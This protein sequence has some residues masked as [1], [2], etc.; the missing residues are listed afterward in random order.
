MGLIYYDSYTWD[1]YTWDWY[2]APLDIKAPPQ[3]I[4][5]ARQVGGSTPLHAAVAANHL[6]LVIFLVEQA[7]VI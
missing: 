5:G 4:K 2:N 3:D 7:Q 1:S 6:P